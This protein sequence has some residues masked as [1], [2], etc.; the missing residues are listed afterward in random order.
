VAQW[1]YACDHPDSK[2]SWILSVSDKAARD[3]FGTEPLWESPVVPDKG[4]TVDKHQDASVLL[5]RTG[6]DPSTLS[7]VTISPLSNDVS[8]ASV[9]DSG[10]SDNV[11]PQAAVDTLF[12]DGTGSLSAD[13]GTLIS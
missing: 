9:P 13:L 3:G 12:A 11:V 7:T 5:G 6:V 1:Q 10:T 8:Q 4:T 2:G